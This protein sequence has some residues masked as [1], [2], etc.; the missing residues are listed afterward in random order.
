MIRDGS[1]P[2]RLKRAEKILNLA[3]ALGVLEE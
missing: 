3:K 1:D 2:P